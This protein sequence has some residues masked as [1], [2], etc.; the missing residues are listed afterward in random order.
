MKINKQVIKL[1]LYFFHLQD[2]FLSFHS[3]N[4]FVG[5]KVTGVGLTYRKMVTD[6]LRRQ[7]H[8]AGT[9]G[10]AVDMRS[11]TPTPAYYRHIYDKQAEKKAVIKAQK[12]F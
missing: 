4:S 8:T 9:N 3:T 2:F 5:M 7:P 10:C 11:D 1:L 6:F 12:K